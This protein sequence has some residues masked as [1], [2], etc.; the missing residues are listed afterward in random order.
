LGAVGCEVALLLRVDYRNLMQE[1]VCLT[2]H[3]ILAHQLN[4]LGLKRLLLGLLETLHLAAS[5][6]VGVGE[7]K[8]EVFLVGD[9]FG[10]VIISLTL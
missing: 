6:D 2:T 1:V 10:V 9:A 7:L 5:S 4:L 8:L 3:I